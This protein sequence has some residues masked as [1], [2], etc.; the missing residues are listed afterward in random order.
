MSEDWKIGD[1]A[2]CVKPDGWYNN[3]TGQYDPG[4]KF[5]KTYK[6][7]G[8]NVWVHHETNEEKEMLEFEEFPNMAFS[9]EWFMKPQPLE[10]DEDD[11]EVIDIM[12]GKEVERV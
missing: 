6:V 3:D 9:S 5:M 10:L 7:V 2:V 1:D 8:V 4:P 12:K 11:Q